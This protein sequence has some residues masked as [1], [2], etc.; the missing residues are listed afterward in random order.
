MYRKSRHRSV[1]VRL[2]MHLFIS[3]VCVYSNACSRCSSARHCPERPEIHLRVTAGAPSGLRWVCGGAVE[4]GHMCHQLSDKGRRNVEVAFPVSQAFYSRGGA[5]GH[6]SSA[7]GS[8]VWRQT[9]HMC[10]HVCLQRCMCGVCLCLTWPD[11]GRVLHIPGS[12]FNHCL[13]N[14]IKKKKKPSGASCQG[15]C[16]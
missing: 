8:P 16:I 6:V 10:L 11:L 14:Q 13:T 5:G 2:L 15:T 7:A 9:S 4:F 12:V 3:S 1:R